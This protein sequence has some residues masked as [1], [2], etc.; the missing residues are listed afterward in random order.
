MINLYDETT[1]AVI[2]AITEAQLKFLRAQLEE[3]SIADSDYYINA[4]TIDGFEQAG[5]DPALLQLLRHALGDR[6][7]MD[8]QW[9]RE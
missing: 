9:V 1:G 8:I 6:E 2:G 7:D 3:E 4:M 5:A